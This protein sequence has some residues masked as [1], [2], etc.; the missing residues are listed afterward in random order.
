[1]RE[2]VIIGDEEI[3]KTTLANALLGWDI[4]PQS[5]DNIYVPTKENASQM[6]T[7]N[8]RLTDT[9]GYDYWWNTVP[10]DAVKAVSQADTI[11]VLLEDILAG[12]GYFPSDDPEWEKHLKAEEVLLKKLLE[13]TDTRD[14]FF[15]I[16]YDTEECLEG[17][18]PLTQALCLA[19]ERF[20]S[21]S[22]HG[23]EGFFCIDPMKALIGAIEAD[24]DAIAQSGILPLKAALLG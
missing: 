11:V 2:L 20:S 4:F 16:P 15:V 24:D 3:G 17:E 9:P 18:I 10:E 7:D 19:R 1:M 23:D 6:L 14:I 12:E 13:S 22:D 21:M 8:I 5:Y